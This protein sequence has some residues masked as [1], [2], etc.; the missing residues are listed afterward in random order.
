M[1]D[2]HTLTFVYGGFE[3]ERERIHVAYFQD[4]AFFV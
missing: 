3:N 2:L 1:L 4:F